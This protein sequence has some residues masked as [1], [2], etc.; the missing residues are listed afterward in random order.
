MECLRNYIGV[1]G[2][3]EAPSISGLYINQLSGISLRMMDFIADDDQENFVGVWNDV[4]D[5]ALKR[6]ATDVRAMFQKRY[7]LKSLR[8]AV[9]MAKNYSPD[10]SGASG[11]Y[12]GVTINIS[13][14][15]GAPFGCSNLEQIYLQRIAFFAKAQ[16]IVTLK[17]FDLATGAQIFSKSLPAVNVVV[18]AWNVIEV[19][20]YFNAKEIFIAI[21][22]TNFTTVTSDISDLR[23]SLRYTPTGCN[24][25]IDGGVANVGPTVSQVT[26]GNNAHGLAIT[27][28]ITCSYEKI[29]CNNREIFGQALLYCLGVEL[30]NERIF[31]DRLNEYTA[32][33]RNKARELRQLF[34][35]YYQGGT[36]DDMT[37]VGTLYQCVDGIQLSTN[38]GC[39][40]CDAPVNS[41][42]G[43]RV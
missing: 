43:I 24:I 17:V 6:F 39:I 12:R 29:V 38:D 25:E 27:F 31:S 14:Q 5:R 35:A 32:F 16:N 23:N 1:Q 22:A 41:I 42:T 28:A 4:Q 21:D 40:E 3:N 37:I 11:Q 34:S 36:I 7:R 30:M 9:E 19:E 33:D 15:H 18:D 20:Q 26:K 2:C 13:G 10:L 8:N